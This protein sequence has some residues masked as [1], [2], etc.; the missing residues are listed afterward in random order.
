MKA[1]CFDG[2]V[3]DMEPTVKTKGDI[4]SISLSKD[5]DYSKIER[6]EFDC[7]GVVARTG[8][9]GYIVLPRS[10]DGCND[11]ALFMFNRH[12]NDFYR[13]IQRCN[14]PIFGV[15]TS[16][17]C[18]LAVVSGMTYDY[19][20]DVVIKNGEYRVYPVF[21]VNGEM[22]YEDFE[23]SI[24]S[25]FGND[26]DYSGMARRYRKYRIEKGELTPMSE[27]MKNS[28]TLKY[29][30]SSVMVRVRCGFKP[31][32]SK[33][34]HQTLENEPEMTVACDFDR[35]GDILDEL[36]N[37]GVE[38]AE[39]CLIGWN[40]KGHDGRWPQMFPVCEELGGEEKLRKLIKKAQDMGYQITCHTNSSDQYEIAD[41]YDPEN[42]RL[43]RFLKPV[44]DKIAWSGGE[45]YQLC[46]KIGYE[47]TKEF[48]PK[49][50]ELG[51]RGTHY[52]DVLGIVYPR[53]CYNKNH[54]VNAKESVVYASKISE[55]SKN[56]FGGFS[57]EGGYDY[58]APYLDYG[59]YICFSHEEDELCD[60][61]VPFWEIVYH[62]YM[63]YNPY[64][65]TVNPNF[66]DRHEQLKL[67]EYGGRPS[68][69]Y[70]SAFMGDGNNWMGA[71]D[72]V[73]NTKEQLS[74]SADKIKK[75]YDE[76]KKLC[77]LQ[78]EFMEKHEEVGSNVFEV[79]YSDGTVIRVDYNSES[80]EV[81]EKEG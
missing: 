4:T 63:L 1:I 74:D 29:S 56:L 55:I 24:F 32:P 75:S 45:M 7:L 15:K 65:A 42:T 3:I 8:D 11:Y 36:K 27:R 18:C 67:I 77:Y 57:S 38:K 81:I 28:E 73:C 5:I 44:K 53:K 76:Y 40:V 43:D 60:K 17:K 41:C 50:A 48:L 49:V 26:A 64:T 59:L 23:V 35:V 54:P 62:G 78:T 79:T 66:K 39:I 14:M 80:Y 46:P 61:R 6:I 21:E 2:T 19:Y 12:K 10:E 22:P 68:Y 51:F 70:Y 16:E 37:K 72:A 33:V 25:L 71:R 58:L 13:K 34:L 31:A 69:Y 9:E 30:A 47:Q 20:M 52:I